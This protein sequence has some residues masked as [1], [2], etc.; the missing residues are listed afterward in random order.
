MH[1]TTRVKSEV[2]KLKDVELHCNICDTWKSVTEFDFKEDK[3]QAPRYRPECKKCDKLR[4]SMRKGRKGK[5]PSYAEVKAALLVGIGAAHYPS[6][7][8]AG[9]PQRASQPLT[10]AELALLR[11]R[12]AQREENDTRECFCYL[13]GIVGDDTYVKIG[14][15]REPYARLAD[16]QAGNPREL[17]VLALLPGGEV[18]ERELHQKFIK[19]HT[20]E[21]VGEWFRKGPAIL[22]EFAA[23]KVK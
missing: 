9:H 19:Y 17:K 6:L 15:S 7:N 12:K 1:V 23:G 10:D 21:C 13:V 4:K 22:N 18:K 8:Q 3:K 20:D 14:H 11:E 2:D 16:Y 5:H